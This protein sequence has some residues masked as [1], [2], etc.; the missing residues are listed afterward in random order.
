MA[1]EYESV[2]NANSWE[3]IDGIFVLRSDEDKGEKLDENPAKKS[4]Q[5]GKFPKS[6]LFST[7][8]MNKNEILKEKTLQTKFQTYR[9]LTRK[10]T[11]DVKTQTGP[12]PNFSGP[13]YTD[14]KD[15][16]KVS[17]LMICQNVGIN[18]FDIVRLV[19]NL[20][21]DI[22]CELIQAP[23]INWSTEATTSNESVIENQPAVSKLEENLPSDRAEN[24]SQNGSQIDAG[25]FSESDGETTRLMQA[26]GMRNERQP[27]HEERDTF[28]VSDG[29]GTSEMEKIRLN[30]GIHAKTE[31]MI[32]KLY[33]LSLL[34]SLFICCHQKS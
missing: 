29:E 3:C 24:E 2:D 26:I 13:F 27:S 11:K 31:R 16:G 9:V 18:Y 12:W 10:R 5:K 7:F 8:G 1:D 21:K 34:D 17:I 33:N 23:K 4:E 28:S 6:N 32:L 15:A 25:T 30:P 22:Q 19:M 20:S 14:I